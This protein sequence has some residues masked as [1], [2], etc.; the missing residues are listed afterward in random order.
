VIDDRFPA[1]TSRWESPNVPDLYFAGTLG[2]VRDFKRSTGGF[3]HGFRYDVRALHRM[4]E[5]R[6]HGIG[7]PHRQLAADPA[8]LTEA[9]ITRVNRTS[10]L[11]QRFE[12]LCDA[13]VVDER[14]AR[15]YEE[16]P[17]GYLLETDLGA[18]ACCFTVTLEYGPGHDQVDPFDVSIGRISQAET[19]NAERGRYLHPVVRRYRG[20]ELV[21]E[22]HITE[23]LE[24][25]W[26]GEGTHRAP[27]RRFFSSELRDPT[28][29]PA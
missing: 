28:P 25:E 18:G 12:F 14:E 27:L 10:A 9:V 13:I 6:Y 16:L 22:H 11:W 23:N 8:E 2:Q 26:T 20:G 4:L 19:E 5:E 7:W 24:N 29:A 21:T 3:I 17:A 1:Q 15:Y